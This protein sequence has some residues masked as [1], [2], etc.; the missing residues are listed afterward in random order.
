MENS[1]VASRQIEA[2]RSELD[3][4]EKANLRK[5]HELEETVKQLEAENS[6]LKRQQFQPELEKKYFLRLKI[7]KK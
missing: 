3:E 7:F 1:V 2:L 4:N 6:V 5:I